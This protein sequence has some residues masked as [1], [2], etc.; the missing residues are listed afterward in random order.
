MVDRKQEPILRVEN[1]TKVFSSGVFFR[2]FT[3]AVRE[4]SF[5]MYPGTIMSLIGESGSGKTTIGRMVLKLLRPTAGKIYFQ[6]QDI[7][8][9]RGKAE[10]REYYRRVQGV[11]Q[12][13]FSSFNPLFRV[14]RVFDMVYD[15]F[16]PDVKDREE[17]TR[18]VLRKVNLN[19]ERVLH[20][21]PHQLSGGQ[22]Q[23]LL[24]ARALLL[25]VKVLIAD[26]LIS[27]LDASTRMGILNLLADICQSTG[28]SVLF[29]TH[30][31]ALGYYISDY[32][33]IMHRGRLVEQGATAEVYHNPIHPYTRMLFRSVPDIGHRWDPKEK[34]VPEQ[35]SREIAE[36]YASNSGRGFAQVS[37]SH[38]VLMSLD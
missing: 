19:P 28:M 25:D 29:I 11:F 31:L 33:M 13:P 34:F 8:T 9:L 16:L 24:I 30:D 15:V 21:F 17:R 2:Q 38:K 22:L 37:S 3:E 10:L 7:A 26:E 18:E 5:E 36:F 35:V 1:L 4:V 20:Q 6:E 12:D 32:T 27:M 23:R 14:D